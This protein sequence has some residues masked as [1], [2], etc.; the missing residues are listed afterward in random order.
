M[1]IGRA[2]VIVL[3]SLCLAGCGLRTPNMQLNGQVTD[4]IIDENA[5]VN[6]VQCELRQ[7]VVAA[8]ANAHGA[9][10]YP[11]DWLANWGAKVTFS[12]TVDE[13]GGLNPGF[14][15]TTPLA[16]IDKTAQSFTLGLGLNASS[17][18]T[19]KETITF[20]YA[21]A[22]LIAANTRLKDRASA[23]CSN[24]NGVTIHSDL[25]IG[26]FLMTKIAVASVPGSI[27][28]EQYPASP[29]SALSDEITF[30]VVGGGNVTPTWKLVRISANSSGTFLNAAR[31][32]TN[33]ILMTL[34]P[35]Q[36]VPEGQPPAPP[37]LSSDAQ[38]VHSAG[39]IGQAVATAT[40]NMSQ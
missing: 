28:S 2:T 16:T 1:G 23:P 15:Y 38:A 22:D 8:L 10:G 35:I 27:A 20:T 37:Q 13:K 24:E 18:A 21:F 31:S 11:V 17:D 32:K 9:L 36:P 39:L 34:G 6:Q 33:D 12:L 7:G 25:R 40:Q 29:Y 19:R 14:S 26:D 30:V 3:L 4:E 5:I